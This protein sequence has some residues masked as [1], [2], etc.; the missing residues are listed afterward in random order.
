MNIDHAYATLPHDQMEDLFSQFLLNSW[1]FSK[2]MS[3]ARNEKAFEMTYI[4]H[5]K[6]KKSATTVAGSAYHTAL[7]CYFINKKEGIVLDLANLEMK[8]FEYIEEVPSYDWKIQKT[9]PT[10]EA[11]K[12][13][14]LK[15][16]NALL[17]NFMTEKSL[18]EDD[19][20]EILGVEEKFT[21]W[22]IV[23]G[24]DI[25]LP[26]NGVID[27]RYRSVRDTIVVLDHKS[28]KSFT[29]EKEL[30]LSM[31]KQAVTYVLLPEAAIGQK[32]D[33][34]RIVENK[35]SKNKDGSAQLR[36]TP[37][38]ITKDTR[39]LYESMLYEPLK[40]FL[41]A[42][43][44]PDYIYLINESDNFV[45]KAELYEFWAKTM[46][47]E[48]DDFDIPD[49]KKELISRR[50]KKVRDSSLATINPTVIKTFK[51]NASSF[52]TYDLS[53]KNMTSPEKIEH[54]LRSFNIVS[55]VVHV[56]EGYS[57]NTYLLELQAGTQNTKLFR[58]RL[59][60]AGALNVKNV[61]INPELVEYEGRAYLAVESSKIRDKDLLFD[62][63]YLEGMKIPIGMDNFN[64][65]VVWDLNNHST[66]HMLICGATG[67]GKS[68]LIK[69]TIEYARLA[70]VDRIIIM[71]PKFEFNE[72]QADKSIQVYNEI[73]E[74]EEQMAD[75]V[76]DM[77]EMVKSGR[78]Q[79][80]LV[81][82]DEFGDAIAA[83]RKGKELDIVEEV[84]VG[85][86]APKK[87][88]FGFIQEPQPKMAMKKT[89]EL[90]SLEQNLKILLQKGRSSG[91]RIVPAT[92]RASTKVITGD[93]KVNLPVQVCFRVP[94]EV[95]S[96]VVID[97]G[98]AEMLAGLG[99]G[100][101]RSPE[102]DD[103]VRFQGFYKPDSSVVQE[104]V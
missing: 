81:F 103:V 9:T 104:A 40:R 1:S 20:A 12:E 89:G 90:K 56:L 70:G 87:D 59:D 38:V 99:D 41:E 21:E 33:E 55:K 45:D 28:K 80:T 6:M 46:I 57:S 100:L 26:A 19:I 71:D 58:H 31:G 11:C 5:Y 102:Y 85:T 30:S 34:V 75:L 43:S 4:Y 13:V 7:E 86:Y 76:K 49:N 101:M 8:A 95:D 22:L 83:A 72:Y 24:V 17:K 65:P 67:S 47:A 91:F 51:E 48:V 15:T 50:L 39:R 77:N 44:D 3:F 66:P 23:N 64:K 10:I 14:A 92:Q 32:I 84:Q 93:A 98:G 53:N 25:P 62:S 52:I 37:V 27:L 2:L 63:K 78:K 29:D 36:V 97:E 16:V 82:F 61:R 54:T 42:V 73:L 60:I 35:F 96:K 79:T 18:Y 74:I 88:A 94:K 69:S 68:V